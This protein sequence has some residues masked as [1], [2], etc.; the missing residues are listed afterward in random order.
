[1]TSSSVLD[2]RM[3]D[4]KEVLRAAARADKN[5]LILLMEKNHSEILAKLGEI[6]SRLSR[7]KAE[8]RVIS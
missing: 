5:E 2:T 8:R 1:M 6:D 3:S 4:V 7:L